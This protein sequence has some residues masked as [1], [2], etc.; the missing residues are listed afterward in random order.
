LKVCQQEPQ[1]TL[2][3]KLTQLFDILNKKK[4]LIILDDLQNIFIPG[5]FTGQYKPEYQDYQTFF[6]MITETEHQSN[7]IVISQEQ[8]TEIMCLDE[9]FCPLNYIE[10]SGLETIE[11]LNNMG[12]KEQEYWLTLIKLYESNP[13]YLKTV[14]NLIKTLFHGKVSKFLAENSLIITKEIKNYCSKLFYRLSPIEQTIILQ[15]SKS[16]QPLSKEEL[17]QNLT[18]SSTDLITGLQSLH[19]RY[20]I[21]TIETDQVRFKISSV[22]QEYVRNYCQD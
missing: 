16:D 2:P 11:I 4:C 10:L 15:I 20:L 14:A 7:V 19:Q 3:D 17:N 22:F 13:I 12:L 9:D 6:T 8:C 18:L 21:T 1:E 5:E